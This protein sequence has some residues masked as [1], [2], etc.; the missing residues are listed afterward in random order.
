MKK[1]KNLDIKSKYTTSILKSLKEGS[2]IK[3]YR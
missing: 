2:M 3:N 1:T